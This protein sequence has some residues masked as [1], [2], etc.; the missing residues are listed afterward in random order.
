MPPCFIH[1]RLHTEYSLID[2]IVRVKPLVNKVAEL[3]M[4]AVAVTD[5]AN[6]FAAVKFYKAAMAMGIKPIIGADVWLYNE[7]DERHPFHLI[8]LCQNITGY[9]NL[10]CIVT[11]AY[12]EG[13]HLGI[14]LIHTA[15]ILSLCWSRSPS[16]PPGRYSPAASRSSDSTVVVA[17]PIP[18]FVRASCAPYSLTSPMLDSSSR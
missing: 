1:L 3:S 11:R 18:R 15:L 9:Q 16:L 5:Q 10:A 8:L 17:G 7:Q 12:A 6:L 2:G 4:P 14:P 13:Q